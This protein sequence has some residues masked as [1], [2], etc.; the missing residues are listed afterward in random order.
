M[1]SF[2]GNMMVSGAYFWNGVSTGVQDVVES[3]K[4]KISD[5]LFL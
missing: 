4:R 3:G 1:W 5:F 2:M